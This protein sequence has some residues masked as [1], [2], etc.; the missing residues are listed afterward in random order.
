MLAYMKLNGM[1]A[2]V[3]F[4]CFLLDDNKT[5]FCRHVHGRK[6]NSCSQRQ[7]SNYVSKDDVTEF[8]DDE[9]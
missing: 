3:L 4:G 8:S 7:L 1:K 2:H 9:Q 5:V 6:I